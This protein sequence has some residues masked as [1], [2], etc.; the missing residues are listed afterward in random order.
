MAYYP[1]FSELLDKYLAEEDRSC[2]WLSQRLNIAPS[3]VSRWINYAK[4]PG[5][6]ETV[7]RIADLLRVRDSIQ[8]QGFLAAAGYGYQEAPK[9]APVAQHA[10]N[11]V[12]GSLAS[13]DHRI[14]GGSPYA[15]VRG[16]QVLGNRFQTPAPFMTPP[17]PPQGILGRD[18]TLTQILQLMKL[19]KQSPPKGCHGSP[20]TNVPPVALRGMGGIGKTTLAIALGRLEI[21]PRLFPDG[22][23]W[24]QLGP[25]PQIRQLLDGW[26]RALGVDLRAERNEQ[27]CYERLQAILYHR[28]M[29]LLIDDVWEVSHGKYFTIA[30]P[31][32]RT[33][34]TTRESPMAHALATRE[35]TIAVEVLKPAPALALLASLAPEAVAADK[36][37]AKRLCKQ[38]GYLPLALKMAGELLANE[39]DVP[40][41]MKRLV[42]QL[43]AQPEARLQLCQPEGRLGL[44]N[45]EP[46]S[47]QAILGMSIKRLGK[48]DQ[49]RFAMLK[50]LSDGPRSC[51]TTCKCSLE[52]AEATLSRFIQR[53]VLGK[54]YRIHALWADYA[55]KMRQNM[56]AHPDGP[57]QML[58]SGHV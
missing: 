24:V 40:S 29:L 58:A 51:A 16:E 34:I 6:P 45:N 57:S 42:R 12:V 47:L 35:R 21:M 39:A 33:L 28:R 10:T 54:G 4:R 20:A 32:C 53:G 8:R 14:I 18:E 46:V 52:E 31:Q 30:G 36:T 17:L 23:L 27:A 55:A 56:L 5:A 19:N 2:A 43:I 50:E 13:G 1:K 3:T 9:E 37:K 41:R 49:E 25:N 22:V 15:F 26:G 7:I 44:S 11:P 38:L 48:T